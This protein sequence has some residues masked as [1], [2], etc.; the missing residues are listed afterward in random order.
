MKEVW[1]NSK[2]CAAVLTN[3]S[4]WF[5]C[6]LHDLKSVSV[7]STVTTF[8][9]LAPME[10]LLFPVRRRHRK[11]NWWNSYGFTSH[12]QGNFDL[13]CLEMKFM[14]MWCLLDLKSISF[15]FPFILTNVLFQ[16]LK[17]VKFSENLKNLMPN[18]CL[19][20][21]YEA[22]PHWGTPQYIPEPA[23]VNLG[24]LFWEKFK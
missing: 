23:L 13:F 16:T 20:L 5:D 19:Y 24:S 11:K 10:V 17:R 1:D 7:S 18:F 14:N 8:P 4:K 9:M 15:S 6:L 22:V 12:T 3:L 2:V 21:L